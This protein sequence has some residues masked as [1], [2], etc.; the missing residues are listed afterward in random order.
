[1]FTDSYSI[2]A[3]WRKH[4]SQLLNVHVVNDVRQTEIQRAEPLVPQSS[5]F[6]DEMA[7]VTLK[8]HRSPDID[9][10]SAEFIKS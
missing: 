9:Q 10:S 1:M 6:E 7:I 5:A 3:T 8:R 2:L 4:F